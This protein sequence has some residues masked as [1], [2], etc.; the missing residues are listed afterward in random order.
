[1]ADVNIDDFDT[2]TAWDFFTKFLGKKVLE[3][4]IEQVFYTGTPLT[5]FTTFEGG[6]WQTKKFVRQLLQQLLTVSTL[7]YLKI[8]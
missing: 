4:E 5:F 8:C 1:M 3:E 6:V 2:R 7:L